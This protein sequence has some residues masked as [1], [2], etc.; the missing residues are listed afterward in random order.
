MKGRV[1]MKK[2]L[3]LKELQFLDAV[4]KELAY[5]VSQTS[6]A[7]QIIIRDNNMVLS[8]DFFIY[9][10]GQPN[11]MSIGVLGNPFA[12]NTKIVSYQEQLAKPMHNFF[13]LDINNGHDLDKKTNILN[14][15]DI[16]LQMFLSPEYLSLA[17]NIDNYYVP[18]YIYF[19]TIYNAESKVPKLRFYLLD[20][21]KEYEV[22]SIL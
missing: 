10:S 4:F 21:A 2:Y 12:T 19:P 5:E 16:F 6:P 9:K 15:M 20:T 3:S 14:N 13:G 22:I 11:I 7:P 1:N 18:P 8:G 17:P